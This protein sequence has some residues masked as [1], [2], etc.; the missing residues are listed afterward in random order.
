MPEHVGPVRRDAVKIHEKIVAV[1]MASGLLFA[2]A[3]AAAMTGLEYLQAQEEY[4]YHQ[5]EKAL[6]TTL[7]IQFVDQGYRDVPD[8]ATLGIYVEELIRQKG[9]RDKDIGEIAEEAAL[10][11][12][13]RK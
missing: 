10:A 3:P 5:A 12:G 4:P 1:V 6:M 11:H 7:I 8:W 2:A 9:Y 13:M